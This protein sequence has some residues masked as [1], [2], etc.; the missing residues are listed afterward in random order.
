MTPRIEESLPKYMQVASYYRDQIVRGDL[1]P[2]DEVPSERQLVSEWG[3][4]RVTATRAL[5]ALRMEGLVDSRHGSGTFVKDRPRLARQSRDRYARPLAD[6]G[7]VA[8]E[9]SEVTKVESLVAPDEV[10]GALALAPGAMAIRRRSLIRDDQGVVEISVAWFDGALAKLAPQLLDAQEIRRSALAYVEQVTGRRSQLARDVVGARLATK[11]EARDL[12]L[13]LPAAVL[14]IDHISLD[15]SHRPLQ[16]VQ[17]VFSPE[18][19]VLSQEYATT[20]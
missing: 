5:A 10:A 8:A 2:G 15:E 11:E 14:T 7:L 17:A 12:C 16:F 13:E 9:G 1:Q 19:F 20:G 3:V 4:S 6:R 18:R